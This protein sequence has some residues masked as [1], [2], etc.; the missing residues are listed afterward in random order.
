MLKKIPRKFLKISL[1]LNTDNFLLSKKAS[2]RNYTLI[3]NKEYLEI[4][5]GFSKWRKHA[6]KV[7]EKVGLKVASCT[8]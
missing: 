7:G 3:L 6:V 2:R 5:K 8:I 1:T 4:Q